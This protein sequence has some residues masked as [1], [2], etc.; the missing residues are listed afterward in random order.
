MQSI[1]FL[2]TIL[3]Y[4]V[5]LNFNPSFQTSKNQLPYLLIPLET[6]PLLEILSSEDLSST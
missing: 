6:L 4:Q 3:I 1:L 5:I 2:I